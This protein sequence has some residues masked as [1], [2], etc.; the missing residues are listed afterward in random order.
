MARE[1]KAG[2]RYISRLLKNIPSEIIAT[3]LAV[4]GLLKSEIAGTESKVWLW[5]VF[6]I[7]LVATP[8][9]LIF[10]E[11]VRMIRQNVFA[12]VSFIIWIMV[13]GGPFATIEGYDTVIG[14][15]LLIICTTLV[16]PIATG[17]WRE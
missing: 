14:S 6:G 17:I 5:I 11:Q 4:E 8:L 16:F 15:I 1:I 9:W 10:K 13:M 7:L 12:T 3:Y 2:D